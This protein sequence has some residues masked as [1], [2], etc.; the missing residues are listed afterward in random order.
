MTT[1]TDIG[2]TS[3][4]TTRRRTPSPTRTGGTRPGMSRSRRLALAGGVF[5]LLTFVFSIPTLGMKAPLEEAG[6]ILGAGGGAT[7]VTWSVLFDFLTGITGI[8]TAVALWPVV[9]R[10]SRTR[11]LG[12]V[13]TRT[14]EAATLVLGA[15]SVLAIVI[16]RDDLAGATG[17]RA[18]ALEVTGQAL[19]AM[20][21]ACF[22]F[23]PGFMAVC[24]A[25]LLGSILY[26]SRLVP[27]WI[28]TLGLIGAPLLLI[29]NLATLFGIWEQTSDA[30]MVMVLPLATW[31]LSV[32]IYLAVKGFRPSPLADAVDA[33]VAPAV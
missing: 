15:V 29:S 14:L 8:G 4:P 7:G 19:M 16:L 30:A 22:L 17:D 5:Y 23:G 24:N 33:E 13:T 2:T 28:P 32:G 27:R 21:D 3:R 20:H 9:K 18:A 11:A 10:H 25:F 1:A 26:G 12:F 6:F 31:E